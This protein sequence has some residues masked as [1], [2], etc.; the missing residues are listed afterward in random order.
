MGRRRRMGWRLKGLGSIWSISSM[1]SNR[2]DGVRGGGKEGGG[3]KGR[4]SLSDSRSEI[5]G[6]RGV[7]SH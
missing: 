4:R 2:R 1:G 3:G 6:D 5:D 7:K